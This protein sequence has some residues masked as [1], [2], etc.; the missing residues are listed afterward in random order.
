M[1]EKN[2]GTVIQWRSDKLDW[3]LKTE[4]KREGQS[5]LIEYKNIKEAKPANS[6]F[7]LPKG[8]KKKTFG[9]KDKLPL[10]PAK[11]K[12]SSTEKQPRK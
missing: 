1:R 9:A 6:L 2:A 5:M 11:P 4:V 8:Y 12:A 10:K 3:P 7:E